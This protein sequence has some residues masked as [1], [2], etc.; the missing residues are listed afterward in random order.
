MRVLGIDPGLSITG[1]GIVGH[2]GSNFSLVDAGCLR[3]TAA[4]PLEQRLLELHSGLVEVIESASLEAV[5]VEALYSNYRHPRTA[6][7]MGH[8]RGVLLLAAAQS[9]L[10]VH[11]YAPTRVKKSLTGRGRASKAQVQNMIQS[12]FGLDQPPSPVDVSDALAV[13]LCH[14]NTLRLGGTLPG[15]STNSLPESL[16]EVMESASDRRRG[17]NDLIKEL[18][19]A[20]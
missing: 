5:A 2:E 15:K 13:A 19:R 6:V 4:L 16:R 14:I 18:L 8:A 20:E 10:P 9:H 1:F 3:M 17:S 12:I 11:S 7:Q